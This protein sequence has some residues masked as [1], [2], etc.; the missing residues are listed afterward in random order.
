MK[1]GVFGD[2]GFEDVGVARLS[3]NLNRFADGG[4]ASSRRVSRRYRGRGR[5]CAKI[6]SARM[7]IRP[8]PLVHSGE[9][10]VDRADDVP[11][12]SS[13]M[14]R[15]PRQRIDRIKFPTLPLEAGG[16]DLRLPRQSLFLLKSTVQ[17][18][19]VRG[20]CICCASGS[21]WE[22]N[23]TPLP[24]NPVR[25]HDPTRNRNAQTSAMGSP[26]DGIKQRQEPRSGLDLRDIEPHLHR[27]G[28]RSGN[29]LCP[30][31]GRQLMR[32]HQP[33]PIDCDHQPTGETA[34][35]SATSE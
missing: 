17:I 20:I 33:G 25:H 7:T 26:A 31:F 3:C 30:A 32:F 10:Q 5:C 6:T 34:T 1:V 23:S 18:A 4:S 2:F 13:R 35:W 14:G 19:A 11:H 15:L 22:M 21:T 12:P 16:C 8:T 24:R 29:R 28:S 27:Q 9:F